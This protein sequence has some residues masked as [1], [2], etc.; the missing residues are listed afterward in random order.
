MKHSLG[1]IEVVG[2]VNALTCADRMIKSAYIEIASI[3]RIGTGM[4]SIIIRG[5][6]ASVQHAIEVGQETAAEYGELIAA[7]VIPRPY[8]GLEKLTDSAEGGEQ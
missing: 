2:N 8:E 4:V 7:R 1:I 5:D 3:K 6:L